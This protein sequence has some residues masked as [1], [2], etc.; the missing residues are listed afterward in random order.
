MLVE[1]DSARGS[2]IVVA[3]DRASE[4]LKVRIWSRMFSERVGIERKT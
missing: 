4:Q 1:M 2:R 3:D